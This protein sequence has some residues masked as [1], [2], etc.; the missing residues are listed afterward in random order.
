IRAVSFYTTKND[1]R[2]TVRICS[3]FIDGKLDGERA[4]QSGAIPY[5]GFHTVNLDVPVLLN[6]GE[7]FYVCVELSK[8]GHAIDR[9]SQIPVLLSQPPPPSPDAKPQQAQP[10][11][12]AALPSQPQQQ[13]Q[14]DGKPW[15]IS[16]A[17]PKQS[18]YYESG[19]WKDL[20][21][22]KFN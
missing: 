8:G 6:R 22:Y 3:R 10:N 2:Y 13:R 19:E 15:V 12:K 7:K 21:D 16:K 1:V 17:E 18:F 20:Y 4:V 9:T 14:S 11:Q 5:T